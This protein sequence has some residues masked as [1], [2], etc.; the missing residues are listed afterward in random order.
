MFAFVTTHVQEISAIAAAISAILAFFGLLYAGRQLKE[1][2]ENTKR[3]MY[4]D[5][6][7]RYSELRKMILDDPTLGDIYEKG[8]DVSQLTKKQ[9]FYI[10]LLIAFCEGLYL[11]KQISV[12]EE[13]AGGS[14]VKFIQHT[15]STP[16]VRS[17]WDEHTRAPSESPFADDFI[18]YAN[19]LVR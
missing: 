9:R 4:L 5:A 13:I 14:W 17:I 18:V 3:Q 11:T 19:S 12:F 7:G 15:L 2:S 6:L 1:N 16:A 8:F 10:N